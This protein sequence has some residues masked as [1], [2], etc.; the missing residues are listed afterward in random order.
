MG[1]DEGK[2]LEIE[3]SSKRRKCT[4][5]ANMAHL[6]HPFNQPSLDILSFWIALSAMRL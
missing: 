4:E 5:S 2:D 3:S 6:T 1:W